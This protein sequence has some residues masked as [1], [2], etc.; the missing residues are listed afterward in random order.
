LLDYKD[1][2]AKQSAAKAPWLARHRAA[3]DLSPLLDSSRSPQSWLATSLPIGSEMAQAWGIPAFS[4]IT[5][6]D[7]RLLRDTPNDT[8]ANV[9]ALRI[10]PQLAAVRDFLRAAW[11]DS[12]FKSRAE[13]RPARVTFTGEVVSPAPDRP[14][15]DLPREGFLATFYNL[16]NPAARIP[17]VASLPYTPGVRRMSVIATDAF[18]HYR[19][20]GLPRLGPDPQMRKLAVE[21]YKIEPDTGAITAAT[22]LG[23]Q[24]GELSTVV[25]LNADILPVRSVVFDCSEFSL[26]G[27]YDPRFLQNLG[28]L[29]PLDARRNTSLDDYNFVPFNGLLAGLVEPDARMQLLFRFGSVGNRLV[30]LNVA[31]PQSKSDSTPRTA[32]AAAGGVS[33]DQL[34][35]KPSIAHSPI[36]PLALQTAQDFWRLDD[37]RL[38]AYAAA[39]I[40]STQLTA[41]HATAA[42]QIRDAQEAYDHNDAARLMDRATSAWAAEMRVYRAADD[43]GNDVVH[44]AI[45]LLLLCVPFSFCME[46][47]LIASP[48]IYKQLTGSSGIFAVMTVALAWFHP[49]FKISSSPLVIVLAFAVIFMSALVIILLYGKFDAELKRIRSGRGVSAQSSVAG[50]SV[51]MS[52]VLLGIASMRRRKFRTLLTS[53]TIV[54]ITFAVLCFT[55]STR[56]LDTTRTAIGAA[57]PFNGMMLRQRGFRAMPAAAAENIRTALAQQSVTTPVVEQ[58]WNVNAADPN[59]QLDLV[60]TNGG[61][62]RVAPV[63]AIVGFSA[64]ASSLHD[65][66]FPR[67]DSGDTNIIYLSKTIAT[68]LHVNAGDFINVAGLRLQ[69]AGIFDPDDFDRRAVSL[70]GEPLRPL[71]YRLGELDA[72]G[73][74][75]A[76]DPSAETLALGADSAAESN[77]SYEHLPSSHIAIVPAAISKLL[78]NASLRTL[79][80][81]LADDAQVKR[82]SDDLSK[83]FS[84]AILAGS[85]SGDNRGVSLVSA[86]NLQSISGA[87]QV[88]VP[89]AIAG[90]IVFN[91]M[92]GSIAERR[93]EIHVYTSLGLAP[94]H[95]GALFVAEAMT[96]GL[97]GSVFGYIIGQGAGTLLSKLGVLGSVTLNYSGTSAMLTMSL[98]L[99]IVF[100]SALVP[101]RLASKIAAPS[102]DRNWKVPAPK[103]DEIIAHLPFTI[104]KTAADGALAYLADFF[105]ANR[106]GSIGK[107]S[108]GQ[109]DPFTFDNEQGQL[110]RGLKT[111]IWLT[112]F[113]LGVRQHLMLLIHPGEFPDI[114]EVQV[115]L[116][117]LSGDDGSWYRMNRTFL[118]LLRQQFLQW[119]SLSPQRM[120][121]YIDTSHTLF[122][123][124]MPS[125][126]K[127]VN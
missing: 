83:R 1:W 5:L 9:N 7:A 73:R 105:D 88:A 122:H 60:A 58:W 93:R 82:I 49:A 52:A 10:A 101:A 51:M 39:G 110:H 28:E 124:P 104:S 68:A 77:A 59:E 34:Q 76:D 30:L 71:S 43:L 23:R 63:A 62:P 111:I 95:V 37:L 64:G 99:L 125:V 57:A 32:L 13:K 55:S 61:F 114:Y 127:M 11:N 4:L 19:F 90:L 24:T 40:S 20:E 112:P 35:S 65:L 56:Y 103:G 29:L 119:R 42:D 117:R 121:H 86:S 91:T 115:V 97:I 94:L 78:P 70:A 45:V 118:T 74:S 107:F 109:V 72:G 17:A 96:Y 102:I 69:V 22:N 89:L 26:F 15:P 18:G 98:I 84:L 75:L 50:G 36:L 108:A 46:R 27:L 87:G 106:E 2:F 8:L 16:Q 33:V 53:I 79:T 116:Q 80:F 14:V 123:G 85:V 113:D 44:A 66:A 48:N 12:A 81:K 3:F 100:L 25:D 41:M 67:L 92:M 31:D 21:A 120:Q 54:L 38:R 47:L 6:D 126:G